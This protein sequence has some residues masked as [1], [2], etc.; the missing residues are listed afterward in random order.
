MAT[1]CV[2][3][4]SPE[5]VALQEQVQVNPVIL[6]AKVS[7]WME[8]NNNG[9]FPTAE[10]LNFNNPVQK[11][12]EKSVLKTFADLG[13][14]NNIGYGE[15]S[16]I[17]EK[18]KINLKRGNYENLIKLDTGLTYTQ[19]KALYE[20]EDKTDAESDILVNYIAN[21]FVNEIVEKDVYLKIAHERLL[22]FLSLN[23]KI[24]ITD[25][26]PSEN[27]FK[28]YEGKILIGLKQLKALIESPFTEN[29]EQL[30]DIIQSTA[31]EE[32]IHLITDHLLTS[33]MEDSIFKELSETDK[34]EIIHIYG[35]N[36]N[37]SGIV[38]EYLRMVVQNRL[39]GK[40]TEKSYTE[41]LGESAELFFKKLLEAISKFFNKI[42]GKNKTS[43]AIDNL[44][45]YMS[46]STDSKILEL[47]KNNPLPNIDVEANLSTFERPIPK[48]KNI[49]YTDLSNEIGNCTL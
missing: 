49:S 20:K 27:P 21:Y 7:L 48:Q 17:G 3:I 28:T 24:I 46:G 32:A 37:K 12:D 43:E 44:Y 13:K 42:V 19:A 1:F 35:A 4:K 6:Q 33:E 45:A 15:I 16:V 41:A 36:L 5:F 30:L 25:T 34:A 10:D 39:F 18:L 14:S 9:D 31:Q 23:K 38:H 47:L 26:L 11:L 22:D 40:I 29:F 2:N 8:K